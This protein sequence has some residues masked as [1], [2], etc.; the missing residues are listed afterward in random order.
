LRIRI[1][2]LDAIA[3][4]NIRRGLSRL[5]PKSSHETD[6]HI[7]TH[8]SS[9]YTW[10]DRPYGTDA[11]YVG[12]HFGIAKQN[13]SPFRWLLLF[14]LMTENKVGLRSVLKMLLSKEGGKFLYNR[15]EEI[16]PSLL[17]IFRGSRF[18]LENP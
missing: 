18:D 9:L 13:V 6:W 15:R 12:G 14:A 2:E 10:F 3:T 5:T 4:F 11:F 1:E 16:L 17:Q 7:T 8:S